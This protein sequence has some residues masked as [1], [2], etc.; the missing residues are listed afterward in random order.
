MGKV[1]AWVPWLHTALAAALALTVVAVYA[2]ARR[3]PA[4]RA[5]ATAHQPQEEPG[6]G[7]TSSDTCRS[8]HPGAYA[9]WARSYHR[10]MTAPAT[11]EF[12]HGQ[13][14][15]Q[16]LSHGPIVFS[17]RQEG[18]KFIVSQRMQADPTVAMTP[19]RP[20]ALVTGS[21][22]MQVYWYE[23]GQGRMLGQL[24]FA[25]LKTDQRWVP[26][27]HLFLHPPSRGVVFETGR[28][29]MSCIT[30]HT[31]QGQPRPTPDGQYDTR[32]SELGIACEACHGPAAAHVARYQSPLAR[33]A[34][35]LSSK[36]EAADDN[37]T[38]IVNPARLDHKRASQICSQCHAIWQFDG[39][40]L[41][42]YSQ[43]GPAYRPGDDPAETMWL[44]APSRAAEDSRVRDVVDNHPKYTNG[45]FWSDGQA[46]VSGREFTGMQDSGCYSRG[47][48]SCLSCH[49]MHKEPGD[50]RRDAAWA[51]DQLAVDREGDGACLQ[52]HDE[53]REDPTAHTGHADTSQGSRCYNCHMPYTSYGLLKAIRSHKVTSPSVDETLETGRLNACN[54]CH[55]DRSL[56]W[57]A[58]HLLERHGVATR[59]E[60]SGPTASLSAGAVQALRGNAAQRALTAWALGWSAAR[61]AARAGDA[62]DRFMQPL[63]GLLMDDPYSAVRYI[64]ERS[65]TAHLES[66]GTGAVPGLDYDFVPQPDRTRPAA[67]TVAAHA[68]GQTPLRPLAR[69]PLQPDG[70]LRADGQ[71]LLDARDHTPINLLE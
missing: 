39:P 16:L 53:Y 34:A 6:P 37:T 43:H 44:F 25:Y 7:Y 71:A 56:S 11:P 41:E 60:V 46:R 19:D 35:H 52:C 54:A 59:G 64:A 4:E 24:P 66:T 14:E 42:A 15:G 69:V 62:G 22:H 30:C 45:Q 36:T 65:L 21:H 2:R 61:Q 70:S 40:D 5:A 51:D 12:V 57:T 32:V 50:T 8:C 67:P 29:N 47:E 3:A 26:R 23:T 58:E 55:I 27:G 48:M 38:D 31:T 9:T 33:Y 18:E 10:T 20:L 49:S 28:W 63:L 68:V 13:F 1:G 17:V